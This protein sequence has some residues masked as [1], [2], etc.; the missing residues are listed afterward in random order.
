MRLKKRALWEG[1]SLKKKD[2][3]GNSAVKRD[4]CCRKRW[5]GKVGRLR[6][7]VLLKKK[8]VAGSSTL[9]W[10]KIGEMADDQR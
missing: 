6:E 8:G 4:E 7:T 1:M 5:S 10:D 9:E 3:V 2:I